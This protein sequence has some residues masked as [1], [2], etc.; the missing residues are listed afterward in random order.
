MTNIYITK[1]DHK[2]LIKLINEKLPNDDSRLSLLKEVERAIIVEPENI[3]ADIITMN[4]LINFT[5]VESGSEL[6]YWLVF[7][8]NADIGQH[9][10]SVVSPIGCALLGYKVGDI[11]ELKTPGGNKKIKVEKILHQPEAEGNYE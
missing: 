1:N 6:E 9:K 7:P 4:S 3:P 8:E 2:K 11:I 5:D 10:I